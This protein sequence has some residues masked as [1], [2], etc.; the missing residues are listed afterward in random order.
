MLDAILVSYGTIN[1]YNMNYKYTTDWQG[2]VRQ[3][4]PEILK[5][6]KDKPNLNFLEIGCW[7]GRTTNWL[8]DNILTHRSSKMTVVDV[9]KGSPEETG[10]N[11]LDLDTIRD[12]FEFNTSKR[13]KKITILEGYSNEVLRQFKPE[14]IFDVAYIDGTHTAYGTLEDA[15]LVHHLIKPG[16]LII[17]DDYGWKDPNRPSPTDSPQLG[18]DCFCAA[19]KDFYD[20]LVVSYQV[21]IRK[22]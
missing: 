20:V 3:T 9:F 5:D 4:W 2:A 7:E 15:I 1:I 19:F 13:S 8:F 16:G 22:K 10:M 17:F 11:G 21:T 6:F 14:P 12:R 18:I